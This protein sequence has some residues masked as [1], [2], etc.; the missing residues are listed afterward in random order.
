MMAPLVEGAGR[1]A[2]GVTSSRPTSMTK[3]FEHTLQSE[4]EDENAKMKM[5]MKRERPRAVFRTF[6][7]VAEQEIHAEE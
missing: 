1:L 3:L 6:E 5:K 4:R 7:A 2:L